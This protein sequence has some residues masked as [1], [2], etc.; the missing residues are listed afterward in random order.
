MVVLKRRERGIGDTII[1]PI[2]SN[3]IVMPF[4]KVLNIGIVVGSPIPCSLPFYIHQTF[5]ERMLIFL[6]TVKSIIVIG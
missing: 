4:Y 3:I 5:S 1:I 2:Y 6:T